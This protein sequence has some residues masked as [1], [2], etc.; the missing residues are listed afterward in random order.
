MALGMHPTSLYPRRSR[1]APIE[2]LRLD[3]KRSQAITCHC[4]VPWQDGQTILF[5]GVA[6][7]TSLDF[8]IL[9]THN[10]L[11]QTAISFAPCRL[12]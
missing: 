6:G 5:L 11:H 7:L 8:A 1:V 10:S 3:R 4:T 12:L 9:Q 2:G